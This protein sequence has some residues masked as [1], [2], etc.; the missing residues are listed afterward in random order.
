MFLPLFSS[1]VSL[2]AFPL[3]RL[4]RSL[5]APLAALPLLMMSALGAPALAEEGYA[6]DLRLFGTNVTQSYDGCRL[7][8]WQANKDPDTDKYA[9]VFYA[10]FNDGEELPAW[11]KVGKEVVSLSRRDGMQASG[12]RLEDLRLYRDEKKNYSVFVEVTEQHEDGDDLRVDKALLTITQRGHFPFMIS[13]KGGIIC[14]SASETSAAD[15][16]R[17]AAAQQATSPV[18]PIRIP[19]SLYGDA[20]SLGRGVAF[21]NLSAVPSGVLDAIGRDATDCAPANTPGMGMRYAI[22]DAMTLWEVPCN[23]YA[24]TGSSVYVTSLNDNPSYSS[25]LVLP[26]VPDHRDGHDLYELRSPQVN[27]SNALVTSAFY[28]GDGTCGSFEAYQLRAV[29]GEALEF[30]LIE[31]REK[32]SCDGVEGDARRFPLIYRAQ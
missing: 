18:E 12:R 7:A 32:P 25:V 28:D 22:S 1:K 4:A 21:N 11:M 23:L 3:N 19:A 9:Y 14:P 5:M 20:I 24:R 15:P 31:Y 8:F 26:S 10:P 16:D 29:E 2:P 27:P 30:F 17:A 6:I 13:V